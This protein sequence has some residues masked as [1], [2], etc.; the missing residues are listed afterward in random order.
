[1]CHCEE[2]KPVTDLIREAIPLELRAHSVMG[3]A[4]SLGSSQ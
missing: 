3:I 1:M 2:A 4:S